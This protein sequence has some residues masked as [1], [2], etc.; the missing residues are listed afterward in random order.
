MCCFDGTHGLASQMLPPLL[1]LSCLPARAECLCVHVHADGCV[2]GGHRSASGVI[3]HYSLLCFLRQGFSLDLE[4][5]DLARLVVQ[6]FLCLKL[7]SPGTVGSCC[8]AHLFYT[9][10][11][12]QTH[13]Q[14]ASTSLT[15]S[16]P[17]L[18]RIDI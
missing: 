12:D 7:P 9:E 18:W 3:L 8:P 6:G 10:A 15:D 1:T 5:M 13:A 2:W 11:R 17:S 14:T 16:L 4:L